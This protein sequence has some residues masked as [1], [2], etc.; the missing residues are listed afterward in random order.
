MVDPV[1]RFKRLTFSSQNVQ[2]R[3]ETLGKAGKVW[4]ETQLKATEQAM[5]WTS[6]WPWTCPEGSPLRMSAADE[7]LNDEG[8]SE[9]QQGQKAF[10]ADFYKSTDVCYNP[11]VRDLHAS[12]IADYRMPISPLM[13]QISVCRTLRNSD[14]VGVPLDAVYQNPPLVRWKDKTNPKVLWR[15]SP[16]GIYHNKKMPWRQAQRER[17]HYFANNM[18][19]ATAP[20]LIQDKDGLHTENFPLKVMNEAWFDVGLFGGPSQCSEED[21]TCDEMETEF[22]WRPSV[23][24]DEALE[25]KYIVDVD[26]NGWSSR[27]RRL[28]K[29]NQVV[30]KSTLFP[31]WFNDLLVP[32]YHY[33]PIR[34]DYADVYDVMAYFKGAPDGSTPG[35]DEVAEEIARNALTFVESHWRVPDMESFMFLVMLEYWR[36]V[37]DD[38]QAASYSA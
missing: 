8:V 18:S 26:G 12:A 17:L 21:G 10:V 9:Q 25:Y 36:L 37:S 15:G 13:P 5:R 24:G 31:E 7:V 27:F 30:L 29:S 6:G 34:F 16:T 4:P 20:V 19:D 1:G 3:G 38:R 11:E 23:R 33:V 2:E 22:E 35:K 28:L 32:W 14:I